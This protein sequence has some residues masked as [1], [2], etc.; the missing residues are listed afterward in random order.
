MGHLLLGPGQD[1]DKAHE[2]V[3]RLLDHSTG[4]NL[5]DTHP[6]GSGWIF[7]IDGNFGGAAGIAEMLL[8]SH[9]DEVRFL[10]ALPKAWASGLVKGLR[11]RN[12]LDVDLTWA[13]GK[14]TAFELRSR[15]DQ[16]VRIAGVGP[17]QVR[18]GQPYSQSM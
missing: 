6:A 17:V 11:A 1:G 2:S 12:G 8:Q 9:E 16:T 14:L 4:P 13:G 3:C 5:F 10:P 18:A 15:K 7:Q